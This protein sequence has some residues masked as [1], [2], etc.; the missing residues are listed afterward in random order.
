MGRRE[1]RGGGRDDPSF[2]PRSP[3]DVFSIQVGCFPADEGLERPLQHRRPIKVT[4][5]VRQ[6]ICP[7]AIFVYGA[8]GGAR[9]P[10][11]LDEPRSK[12]WPVSNRVEW[13]PPEGGR[14]FTGREAGGQLTRSC[15]S[16]MRKSP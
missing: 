11:A 16:G 10:L 12:I 7:L 9:D 14:Q 13:L 15:G 4:L 8:G 2:P 1:R 6:L 5:V 3:S